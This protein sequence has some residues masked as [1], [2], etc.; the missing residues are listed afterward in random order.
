M[1]KNRQFFQ[2]LMKIAVDNQVSK[3]CIDSL[4]RKH[5]VILCANDRADEEWVELAMDLGVD[6]IISPD[7]DIP[8]YLD[9]ANSD[10]IWI[11]LPQGIKGHNQF[12]FLIKAIGKIQNESNIPRL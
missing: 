3:Q 5:E 8:N 1:A 2:G 7:L 4:N 10:I 6:I 12:D 11:E 9:K